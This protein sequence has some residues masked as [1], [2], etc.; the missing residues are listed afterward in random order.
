[1]SIII[2]LLQCICLESRNS[3]INTDMQVICINK[4]CQYSF[5]SYLILGSFLFFMTFYSNFPCLNCKIACKYRNIWKLKPLF[6]Q[7]KKK[8]H[9]SRWVWIIH[10]IFFL[11]FAIF[12]FKIFTF[13]WD[14]GSTLGY[15]STYINQT[16]ELGI[17]V[18]RGLICRTHLYS[19]E[20]RRTYTRS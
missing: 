3:L 16:T 2:N 18:M 19:W 14:Q 5:L 11:F 15:K 12:N 17:L 4:Y 1:M 10:D 7:Q 9:F 20:I 8:S 13:I 6:Q